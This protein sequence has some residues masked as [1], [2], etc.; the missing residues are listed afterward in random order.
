[1]KKSTPDKLELLISLGG[2]VVLIGAFLVWCSSKA[3]SVPGFC[4]AL[5]SVILFA[6]VCLRF[7]PEWVH[8]WRRPP[9]SQIARVEQASVHKTTYKNIE[10][11]IF[12][13][14]ILVNLGVIVA[15]F[16]LRR[17]IGYQETFLDSLG[18][19]TGTDS[20]HYLSIA[21]DWY[22]SEGSIDRL[23]QL[24][25]LPGYP[26]A[27][28]LI[29]CILNNYLYS[30]LLVSLL[31]FAGA[32]CVIYRLL[33][34]DFDHPTAIRTIKYFC[35][36][37]GAFFFTAP[38]S[39]SLFLLL[40][41]FCLYFART[42]RWLLGCLFGAL[43]AFTRSLG[44]TLFV[45][46]FF[47]LIAEFKNTPR[48]KVRIRSFLAKFSGL[49]LIFLGFGVY[50]LINY[51]VAGNPFQF[52]EYQK[53]HWSQQLGWFFNTACYQVEE[54]IVSYSSNSTNL[55]GLWLPNLIAIFSSLT[56]MI[57]AVRFMRPS[58]TA[59]YISYFFIAVGATWLLSAP[60]YLITLIP[61]PLAVSLVSKKATVNIP[62][63]IISG[64][65]YAL[66]FYA[67]VMRWQVW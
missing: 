26:I 8:F 60:R 40:C 28:R 61:V 48:E 62:I 4:S 3:V 51:F 59:W 19:W 14:L 44:L 2:L 32:G 46:L 47:E 30:G 13:S 39:E 56:I 67:F 34:L 35:L 63:S 57:F 10:L 42:K 24:V 9:V 11:K 17:I 25:F 29:N 33:L 21:R 37:P 54:A 45:P 18:F 12:F 20:Y 36:L 15:A 23:V 64:I 43:A 49:F 38:M 5:L 31:S 58:Y 66:Y 50:C 52:L 55:W 1:M 16:L 7:V 27:V 65:L 6:I 22:L 41:A 53:T